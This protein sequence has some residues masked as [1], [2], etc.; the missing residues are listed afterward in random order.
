MEKLIVII[1]K[2][3]VKFSVAYC[4][5]LPFK[6]TSFLFFGEPDFTEFKNLYNKQ[7]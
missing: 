6:F 1:F 7:Y 4:G 2:I 5:Y 3:I